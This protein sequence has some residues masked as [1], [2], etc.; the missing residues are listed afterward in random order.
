MVIP[1]FLRK[2]QKL[3]TESHTFRTAGTAHSQ[4]STRL[5]SDE[6]QPALQ[7]V[8]DLDFTVPIVDLNSTSTA[9][10]RETTIFTG[11]RQTDT[12]HNY[13]TLLEE[14]FGVWNVSIPQG[15]SE[16]KQKLGIKKS[17]QA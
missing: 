1:Y 14:S 3:G 7:G 16:H 15:A 10:N 2:S 17:L 9:K 8:G 12:Q 13:S 5:L 6:V 4:A 11:L